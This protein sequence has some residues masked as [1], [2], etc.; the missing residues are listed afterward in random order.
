MARGYVPPWTGAAQG[1]CAA[2]LRLHPPAQQDGS[3]RGGARAA[4]GGDPRRSPCWRRSSPLLGGCG[5]SI[6]H[7]TVTI[8]M[9]SAPDSLDPAVGDTT[10]SSEATWLVYTGLVTYA[11]AAGQAGTKLIPGVAASLPTV[12]PDGKTYTFKLRTNL[13]YSNGAPLKASDVAYAIQRALKLNWGSAGLVTENVVG[14]DAFEHGK[15]HSITGIT[16]NNATAT[17]VIHL[18]APYGPFLN[19]LAFP[20]IAPVPTGT[21]MR[22]LGTSP[23]PG[24]GPYEIT[25]VNPNHWFTLKR[26]PR[27]SSEHI[28][29][30]PA[31]SSDINVE[32]TSNTSTEAQQV[33]NGDADVFD[34]NDT[35]PPAMLAQVE[36][37]ARARYEKEPTV[38]TEAFFL[39][40]KSAPFNS[41]LV[42]EAVNYAIDRRA[43]QRLDSGMLEPSCHFLPTG[44]PGHP[45]GPCP[46]GNPTAA[47]NIQMAKELIGRSGLAGTS[48]SVWG[49][50]RPPHREYVNYYT[51][52][53]NTIGLKATAKVVQDSVYYEAV[54]NLSNK[55]QTGWLSFSQDFPNPTDFY[56]L[57]DAKSIL[58]H[59]N[60]NLSQVNNP[61]IQHE[62]AEL[63]PVPSSSLETVDA[64]WQALDEYTTHN[65]YLAVFGYDEAPKFTSGRINFGAV[66]FHPVY[67]TDWSSLRL[68]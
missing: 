29:G 65:G 48:V 32:L 67:G 63:A 57:L 5:D 2:P 68:K 43:L 61:H 44:M 60:H 24:I 64:R 27:W 49:G 56:Q 14:A 37:Q 47:P 52:L 38:S 66:I 50:A 39:N 34:Y 54:G 15:T 23:P 62:L 36:P 31:G 11:H 53:L 21:P 59:E 4:T 25:A 16:T 42:R 12:S 26:N 41:R 35:I 7:G 51:S 10:Q 19:V 17:V 18:L 6:K 46:Y 8:L 3:H 33:L 45:T 28:P 30:V 1:C 55:A 9:G 22:N 58:R 20:A 40:T 13:V